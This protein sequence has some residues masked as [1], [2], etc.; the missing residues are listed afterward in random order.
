MPLLIWEPMGSILTDN[1]IR[2]QI[3]LNQLRITPYNPEQLGTCSYDVRLDPRLQVV[4][5]KELDMK[6]AYDTREL[7]IP[8]EGLVLQPGE[9]YLGSTIERSYTPKHVPIYDGRSTTGRYFISSHQTAGFGDIG[10]DGNWTLEITVSRPVRIYPRMRIGQ[11][12]FFQPHG[13]I[14]TQYGKSGHYNNAVGILAAVP[15]NI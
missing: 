7:L 15:N 5:D 13:L 1:E 9:L 10:Y 2:V 12:I 6:R 3:A 14:E 11:L 8:E 4:I